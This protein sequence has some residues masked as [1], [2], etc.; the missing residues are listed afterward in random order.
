MCR[1]INLRIYLDHLPPNTVIID[2]RTMFGNPFRFG[3]EEGCSR[4]ESIR[5]FKAYF[6]DRMAND[7]KFAKQ[8]INKLSKKNLACWCKPLSCHGDII[9][10]WLKDNGYG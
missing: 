3:Y 6:E 9:L 4:K 1:V 7:K 8:V 10:K 2:R 5:K